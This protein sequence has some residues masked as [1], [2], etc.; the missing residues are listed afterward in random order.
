MKPIAE[1][2][3]AGGIEGSIKDVR[4]YK[5]PSPDVGTKLY[6]HPVKKLHLSLQ[7]DKE[8][9]ELLAVTYT[10]DE[11][12]IVE[13]LWQKSPELTDEVELLETEIFV[14][15]AIRKSYKEALEQIA[16]GGIVGESNNYKYTVYV[17]QQIASDA[18]AILRKAQEK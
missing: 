4:F 12:R 8:T 13:V 14:K 17:M 7:K 1:I 10:D 3:W 11:H 16:T 9:G 15:D 2:V 6:T 18:L 5:V